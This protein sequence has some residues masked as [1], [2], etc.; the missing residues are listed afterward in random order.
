MGAPNAGSSAVSVSTNKDSVSSTAASGV[1]GAQ[2]ADVAFTIDAA[3][4]VAAATGK[5]VTL[6]FKPITAVP[7][8]GTVTLN[9][10]S[11]FFGAATPG[12]D[13]AV[14]AVK[15][16]IAAPGATSVVMTV[17]ADQSLAVDTA[18]TITLTG[19]TM[20]APNAGSSAVTVSTSLDYA[21]STAASGVIGAQ[22]A[23]VA[24]T[25]DAA[26]RVAAATGKAVTLAFKPITAVPA[27]G[28]VT[29]NYPS[30]FFGAA[31]PTLDATVG[32]VKLT[33]AAPGATSVV[34]TVKADK[35]L[36]ANTAVTITL[37]GVTMGGINA[38]SSAVTVSTSLDYASSAAASG[39]LGGQV[40]T[41]SLTL[42]AADRFG[43]M[44][45]T[46]LVTV[47]FTP[48]LA[49][50]IGT[51]ITIVTPFNYFQTRAA[52]AAAGT[53]TITCATA[54]CTSAT[55]GNVAVINVPYNT[56]TSTAAMGAITVVTGGAATTANAITITFGIGTFTT[57]LPVASSSSIKV[58][59]TVDSISS[60]AS[61]TALAV[62]TAPPSCPVTPPSDA[63]ANSPKA[64]A[65]A[66]TYPISL[67]LAF[68]AFLLL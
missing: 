2:V 14:G 56:T 43:G 9:Y 26:D 28:T 57:G 42:T 35:S 31:V 68:L 30:G 61:S 37:S 36:S 22:V 23:D 65:S 1:I 33:I 24:F 10:P 5:A 52:A 66:L 60:A 6:A 34:M 58:L 41:V 13:S 62:P 44:T 55:V 12:L 38:G 32:A 40:S 67:L 46:G 21:S 20:G 29:L 51:T 15:L 7:A 11:G 19:V 25:I 16:T 45:T 53:S 18:V 17:K 64:P 4:R 48:S 54:A 50:P 3:D 8:T 59:S 63:P 27:T 47:A 49:M 39:A